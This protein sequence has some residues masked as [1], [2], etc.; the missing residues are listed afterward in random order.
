MPTATIDGIDTYYEVTGDGPPLLLFSPGGFGATLEN[1]SYLG[2]YRELRLVDHLSEHH[3]CIAFDRRESGRSGGR[4][5]RA[6]WADYA[7]QGK[8]LLDHLDTGRAHLMGGCVGC[9]IATVFAAAYPETSASMVLFSPAGGAK[10]RIK[11]HLRFSQHLGYVE[12]HG[13]PGVVELA[14]SHDHGFSKDPRVGPWVS[15][16]RRD[17]AFAEAYAQQDPAR[18]RNLVTGLA[19]TMF[20]RD[21]VPGPEPEDLL[22]LEVP[23]LVIPGQDSSHATS[24]ARFLEECLPNSEYWDVPVVEQTEDTV[25]PRI[26]EFLAGVG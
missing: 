2:R 22:R 13:L 25:A 17:A 6:T 16:V 21:T 18:Y 7:W 15:V 1:W 10:Y 3:T 9:S 12:E 8:A 11:Q 20:D 23:A 19:R 5:E 26:L 4:L 14:R 24:A